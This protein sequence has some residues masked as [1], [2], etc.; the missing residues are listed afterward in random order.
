MVPPSHGNRSIRRN[1]GEPPKKAITRTCDPGHDDWWKAASVDILVPRN[2][3]ALHTA[4]WRPV[5]GLARPSQARIERLPA[6]RRRLR[7]GRNLQDG[8]S[9]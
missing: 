5:A 8:V 6:I 4:P 2:M 7:S 1:T 3:G 9:A